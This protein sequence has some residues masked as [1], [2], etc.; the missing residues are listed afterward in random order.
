M[1]VTELLQLP[2]SYYEIESNAFTQDESLC[3][4]H[5]YNNICNN[6][7][8]ENIK[9]RGI[10]TIMDIWMHHNF[11]NERKLVCLIVFSV[12]NTSFGRELIQGNEIFRNAITSKYNEFMNIG[13]DDQEFIEELSC[14]NI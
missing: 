6:S 4:I 8:S 9:I 5:I 3:M 13:A 10:M 12:L 1:L 7:I 11:Q 2:R 14:R